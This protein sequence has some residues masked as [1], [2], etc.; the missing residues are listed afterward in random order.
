MIDCPTLY[1]SDPNVFKTCGWTGCGASDTRP[2]AEY[3]IWVS[4]PESEMSILSPDEKKK[5]C[6]AALFA[7]DYDYTKNVP[8]Y[9]PKPGVTVRTFGATPETRG[10]ENSDC[11]MQGIINLIP[12][13]PNPEWTGNFKGIKERL[14]YMGYESG[15]TMQAIPYDFR[16]N[17]GMDDLSKSYAKIIE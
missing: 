7:T 15:L 4:A 10:K 6:F 3:Q 5:N 11:G 12:D 16:L 8:T 17:N 2:E 9:K 13:I 14:E 1:S